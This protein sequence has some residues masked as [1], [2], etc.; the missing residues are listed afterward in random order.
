MSSK[1]LVMLRRDQHCLIE[2]YEFMLTQSKHELS[3]L[4]MACEKLDSAAVTFHVHFLVDNAPFY[5][6][7]FEDRYCVNVDEMRTFNR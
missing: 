6:E 7:G 4:Q 5:L 3:K 2:Q 1:Y